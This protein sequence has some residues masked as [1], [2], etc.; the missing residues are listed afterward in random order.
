MTLINRILNLTLLLVPLAACE[1]SPPPV[2]GPVYNTGKTN[3]VEAFQLSIYPLHNPRKLTE[4][5][6][7][8]IDYLNQHIAD[9]LFELEASRDSTSSEVKFRDRRPALLL[10]NPWQTLE[11]MKLVTK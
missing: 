4:S 8:L 6:Q 2:S 11:A 7:L 5:Y 10:P 9:A 1:Q 3:S